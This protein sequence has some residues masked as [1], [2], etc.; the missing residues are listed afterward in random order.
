MSL[1]VGRAEVLLEPVELGGAG[2]RH[3]PALLRQQPGERDL[4]GRRLLLACDA[5]QQIDQRLV[6]LQRLRRKTRQYLP[7]VPS[8]SLVSLLI[9]PVRK[10]L[11]SGLGHETDAQ[12]LAG[13]ENPIGLRPT[14][15]KRILVLK[16]GD[17]VNR[18]GAADGL[19]TWLRE[20]EMLHLALGDQVLD[21]GGYVLDRHVR[22]DAMLIEEINHLDAQPLQRRVA[23]LADVLGPV[24]GARVIGQTTASKAQN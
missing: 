4:R 17:R 3:D 7:E 8:P 11:P 24:C 23:H 19:R 9:A 15:P 20:A 10:P 6:F 18:V 5:L 13:V 2:D 1:D 14:R 16:R 12:F 21:R 22:V